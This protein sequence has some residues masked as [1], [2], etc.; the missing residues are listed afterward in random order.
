MS[1]DVG[2][3]RKQFPI[4][5]REVRSRTADLQRFRSAMDSAVVGTA[6]VVPNSLEP[7]YR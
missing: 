6:S 1:L 7:Q 2:A 4:L 5:E 3:I